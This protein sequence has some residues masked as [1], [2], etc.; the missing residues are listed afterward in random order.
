MIAGISAGAGT[1]HG[2]RTFLGVASLR[3]FQRGARAGTAAAGLT[4]SSSHPDLASV[5]QVRIGETPS[6]AGASSRLVPIARLEPFF[7][8]G[9]GGSGAVGGGDRG[10]E[11]GA[12]FV[13]LARSS[14]TSQSKP[15]VYFARRH[16]SVATV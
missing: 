15:S 1:G 5:G 3:R 13:S 4:G 6:E 12:N 11:M 9:T 10:C 16:T 2:A 7:N 8:R 14:P